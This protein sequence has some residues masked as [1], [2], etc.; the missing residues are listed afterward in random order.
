MGQK[1]GGLNVNISYYLAI[2]YTTE[3]YICVEIAYY[4]RN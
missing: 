3:A 4:V 1:K 2:E